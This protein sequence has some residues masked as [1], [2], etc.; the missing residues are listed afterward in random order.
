MSEYLLEESVTGSGFVVYENNI[1]IARFTGTEAAY[2][3]TLF[4]DAKRKQ[5][6]ERIVDEDLPSVLKPQAS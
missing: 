1:A 6:A 5:A 2:N 4:T 3:A